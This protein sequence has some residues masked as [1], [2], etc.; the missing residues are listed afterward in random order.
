VPASR[1]KFRNRSFTAERA[2]RQVAVGELDVLDQPIELAFEL[3]SPS[4]R[5]RR[6]QQSVR[7]FAQ[8]KQ[9]RSAERLDVLVPEGVEIRLPAIENAQTRLELFDTQE[10]SGGRSA[11][12]HGFT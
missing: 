3:D 10:A 7:R 9:H 12:W 2:P 8:G 4:Q 11:K 1:G 5:D 6:R